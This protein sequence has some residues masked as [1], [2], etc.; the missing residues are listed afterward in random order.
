MTKSELI[1]KIAKGNENLTQKQAE[2]IVDQIFEAMMDALAEGDRIDIRGFGRFTV[3]QREARTGRNPKT[4]EPVQIPA[5]RVP[6]FK[7]GKKL[8]E[9][10]NP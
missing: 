7:T 1:D 2:I 3:K 6:S 5:K 8:Q 9:K 10:M 4:G